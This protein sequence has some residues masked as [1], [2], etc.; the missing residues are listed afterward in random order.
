MGKMVQVENLQKE[1]TNFKVQDI[2]FEINAGEI[3]GLIGQNGNGKTTIIKCLLNLVPF[4]GSI[5]IFEKDNVE[6]DKQI[7]EDIGVIFDEL[8]F[9]GILNALHVSRIM[10]GIYKNW[11]H[12]TFLQ[13]LK[14]FGLPEKQKFKEYSKGMCTK[15]MLAVAL[16]HNAKFLLLDEPTSGIDP[17]SRKTIL[18]E[19]KSYV[20]DGDRAALFSTHITGDLEQVADKILCISQGQ[21][22]FWGRKTDMM[23]WDNNE[24]K[25]I[26]AA[27][28]EILK[29]TD[30]DNN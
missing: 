20:K 22:S 5:K 15:L 1:Y 14:K 21:V 18:D 11:S 27:M 30:E 13:Y 25:T 19:L 16:S 23:S 28:M 24:V 3:V 12:D 17:V 8:P 9:E 4:Q 6:F 26:D 29:N 10:K 7:K 2:N